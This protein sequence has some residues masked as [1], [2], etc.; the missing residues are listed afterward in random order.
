[1]VSKAKEDLPEPLKPVMTTNLSRGMERLRF[2]RLC[3]RAPPILMNSLAMSLDSAIRASGPAYCKSRGKKRG[4]FLRRG[5]FPIQDEQ[6]DTLSGEIKFD[7]GGAVFDLDGFRRGEQ[8]EL[9]CVLQLGVLFGGQRERRTH[10]SPRC[11]G[12]AVAGVDAVVGQ[13][14]RPVAGGNSVPA[15]V[16]RSVRSGEVVI[17]VMPDEGGDLILGATGQGRNV[18]LT[19]HADVANGFGVQTRAAGEGELLAAHF[20]EHAKDI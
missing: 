12:I 17:V 2:L 19:A 6:R 11:V 15:Q 8:L 10:S 18:G 14:C 1:M 3:W 13:C 9:S 7:G 4:P 20:A 16:H 5:L